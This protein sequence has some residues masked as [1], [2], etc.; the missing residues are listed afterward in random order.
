VPNLDKYNLKRAEYLDFRNRQVSFVHGSCCLAVSTYVTLFEQTSCQGETSPMQYFLLIMTGGYFIYDQLCMIVLGIC[1]FQMFLHHCLCI[2]GML[3]VLYTDIGAGFAGIALFVTE[4]SNPPMHFRVIL[5]MAGMRYTRA[6]EIAEY[7]Y[8]ALFFLGRMIVG[9]PIVYSIL[10]CGPMNIL[11]KIFAAGI[12]LQS[13]HFLHNMY[14]IFNARRKETAER[15]R[16]NLN[17][18]GLFEPLTEAELSECDFY[19][20][21]K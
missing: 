20:K 16:R 15:S 18:R 14:F 3:T 9:H 2:I 4:V 7:M 6:Y 19:N 10:M 1:T 11:S 12:L 8:F 21:K 5:R 17:D 13:Y